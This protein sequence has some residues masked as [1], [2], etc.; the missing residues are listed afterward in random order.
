MCKQWQTLHLDAGSNFQQMFEK[1]FRLTKNLS[2]K[3]HNKKKLTEVDLTYYKIVVLNE[4]RHERFSRI[5]EL[6]EWIIENKKKDMFGE[7]KCSCVI[8]KS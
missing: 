6:Y 3:L 7:Q 1:R 4:L 2:P 5:N 8:G